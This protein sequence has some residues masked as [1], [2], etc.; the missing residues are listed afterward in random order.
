MK[1]GI[2]ILSFTERGYRLALA[3]RQ[4]L[5]RESHKVLLYTKSQAVKAKHPE[6]VCL[7]EGLQDWCGGI[8]PRVEALIFVG[9]SGIAVR[10]IAPFLR[11]KTEDPAVLVADEDGR[12]IISLLSG[13]LGGAN[14]LTLFLAETLGADPVITTAS[15][16]RKRLAIDVWAKK[17]D[18]LITDFVAA[19][20][21]AAAIVA[22]Q[23]VDF[24]CHGE[25]KGKIPEELTRI[26]AAEG[27]SE[28]QA[29]A[30]EDI[31][32]KV[33]AESFGDAAEDIAD[34]AAA[35]RFG[36][37]AEDIADEVAAESLGDEAEDIAEEAEE[38][39]E[40]LAKKHPVT[41]PL[42][43][44]SPYTRE[45]MSPS[46]FAYEGSGA[47]AV[48]E[49]IVLHLVPKVVILGV[50][51]KRGKSVHE[52]RRVVMEVLIQQGVSR[53]S[54][55]KLVS[56]DRKADE[57]GLLALAAEWDIPFQ[58]F[59]VEELQRLPGEFSVSAFVDQT[60]GVGNVCERAAVAALPAKEQGQ[61]KFL[62]RKVAKDGV[63]V[64]LVEQ[65]WSVQF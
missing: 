2:V 45:K 6:A 26:F 43:L 1:K 42:V 12:H 64:A 11:S 27:Q 38:V 52:I 62:C 8:F 30:A 57:E 55:A 16:V 48:D 47:H 7:E 3:M 15:D 53:Y 20:A 22:G 17:N 24:Y 60:V 61:A 58:V 51:C 34:K 50:G 36:G 13:H 25:V 9:A 31:A 54:V 29:D 14:A 41:R 5:E 19:K 63:T 56:I 37:A 33:A 18:L 28:N 49:A 32:E 39:A 4:A 21:V 35:E 23:A 65:S 46:C 44:V 59:S 10:T 40:G